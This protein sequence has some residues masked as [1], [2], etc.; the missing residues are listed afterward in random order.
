MMMFLI[1]VV[2]LVAVTLLWLLQPYYR[3]PG[4]Q[5][6]SRTQLNIEIYRDQL[7]RVQQDLADGLLN[8]NQAKASTAEIQARLLQETA[9]DSVPLKP[10]AS[11][12]TVILVAIF[13]PIA[14]LV[15]YGFLGSPEQVFMSGRGGPPGG[16]SNVQRADI[17]RMVD[18]LAAK[19]EKDPN[20][21]QGWAM[22]ARSYK[23]LGR[24]A[25]AEKAYDRAGS[26][27]TNDAQLLADYADAA[28]ANAKGDFSGKPI[29]LIE[30][31]LKID[32]QNPMALW[33]AASAAL[34]T[35]DK[36]KAIVYLQRLIKVLPP[37]SEDAKIIRET[38]DKL[39]AA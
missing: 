37:E 18:G 28:A 35:N 15:L 4:M 32:P 13:V 36:N 9:E 12:I 27:V 3:R 10:H 11:R 7:A 25:D 30:R 34:Q 6:A 1:M 16:A 23:V 5:A 20:N 33:L 21:Q 19:L 31:A 2:L 14:A 17:E 24:M 22:L 38:I 8:E 26:F 29:R 39:K